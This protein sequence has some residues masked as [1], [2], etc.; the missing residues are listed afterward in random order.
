MVEPAKM[1]T[2][3]SHGINLAGSRIL[4]DHRGIHDMPYT[5]NL[6]TILPLP[7]TRGRGRDEGGAVWPISRPSQ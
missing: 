5:Q 2:A 4:H 1:R 6:A 3:G 7:F